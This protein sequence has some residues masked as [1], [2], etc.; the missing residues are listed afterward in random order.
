[1][2]KLTKIAQPNWCKIQVLRF[3]LNLSRLRSGKHNLGLPV[4]CGE[5]LD[6]QYDKS[7]LANLSKEKN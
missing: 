3:D 7:D 4:P 2:T 5:N 6:I 1:M